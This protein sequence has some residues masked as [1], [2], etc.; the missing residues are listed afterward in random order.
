MQNLKSSLEIK[1]NILMLKTLHSSV[2]NSIFLCL[3][4]PPERLKSSLTWREGWLDCPLR[5]LSPEF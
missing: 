1:S 5:S 4:L 2:N 3:F